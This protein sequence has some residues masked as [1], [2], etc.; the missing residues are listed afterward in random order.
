MPVLLRQG[1]V[2]DAAACPPSAVPAD[3]RQAV[4]LRAAE[5]T[6]LYLFVVDAG[7]SP[8]PIEDGDTLQ[9]TVRPTPQVDDEKV[10]RVDGVPKPLR[11]PNAWLL[12]FGSDL[13]RRK[14]AQGFVRGFYDVVLIRAGGRRDFVV[15]A[16]PFRLLG[17]PGAP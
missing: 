2:Q 10:L 6:D 7:S 4:V 3:P 16:S 11:G 8:V 17:E 12:S 13:T 14:S 1:V 5:D 9:L 15:P